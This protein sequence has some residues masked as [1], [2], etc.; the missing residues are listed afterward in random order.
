MNKK[1]IKIDN[2]K[3]E[4]IGFFPIIRSLPNPHTTMVGHFTFLDQMPLKVY[5]TPEFRDGVIKMG[6]TSHPHR[7]IA[8]LTYLFKGNVE[9]FDSA[10]HHGI[11]GEGGMQWMNSGNGIVH[12][13]TIN[14]D[15]QQPEVILNGLQFWINLPAKIKAQAPKYMA[16]QKDDIPEITLE[17]DIGILRIAVDK[18]QDTE[19]KVPTY[20][21]IFLYHINLNP[22]K[23]FNMEVVKGEESAVVVISGSATVNGENID[24]T[25]MAMFDTNQGEVS[26]TNNTDKNIDLVFF[27]GEKYTESVVMGGP[28][29]MNT[30]EE[31]QTANQDYHAGRYGKIDK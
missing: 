4:H 30:Q 26:I 28:F 27:G 2:G 17:N 20:S 22:N 11:V 21:S 18:Y 23:T 13:E 14:F 10:G 12:N 31:M 25:Q 16:V 1:I 24:A 3:P 19:S 15:E 8:T 9:H 5:P 7:G 29:I 6:D